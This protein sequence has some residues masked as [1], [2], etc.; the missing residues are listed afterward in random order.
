MRC[1]NQLK[2]EG[3]KLFSAQRT[4]EAVE[5]YLRARDNLTCEGP[6]CW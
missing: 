1:S 5:K 6:R 4:S 3:N 2:D